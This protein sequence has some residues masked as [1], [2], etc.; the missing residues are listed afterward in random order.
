[1]NNETQ[2]LMNYP[3]IIQYNHYVLDFHIL[4]K[5][6]QAFFHLNHWYLYDQYSNKSHLLEKMLKLASV[7]KFDN[8]FISNFHWITVQKGFIF[9]DKIRKVWILG[10]GID[11]R[12]DAGTFDRTAIDGAKHQWKI[13]AITR[14]AP[15]RMVLQLHY[16]DKN[17]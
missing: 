5:K 14:W 6:Y 13:S 15:R 2:S 11:V 1:M 12:Y 17:L 8:V 9:F 16:Y 10:F 3:Q 4:S 7:Y